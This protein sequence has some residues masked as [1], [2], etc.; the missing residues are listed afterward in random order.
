M[1]ITLSLFSIIDISHTYSLPVAIF[2]YKIYTAVLIEIYKPSV[3]YS[4]FI[5]NFALYITVFM[6]IKMSS[7]P[8]SVLKISRI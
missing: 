8:S 6:E 1:K 5:V 4:V 2:G 7:F 3:L